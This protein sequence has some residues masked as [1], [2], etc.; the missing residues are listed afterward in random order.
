VV[1]TVRRSGG[2]AG[3]REKIGP[4]DTA[5]VANGA[6]IEA[7]VEQVGF[8]DLPAELPPAEGALS[9]PDAYYHE[10]EVVDGERQHAV[11]IPANAGQDAAGLGQLIGLVM[12]GGAIWQP[13]RSVRCHDWSAW[14]DTDGLHVAG[15]C[16]PPLGWHLVLE[17]AGPSADGTL[18][19]KSRLEQGFAETG[20]V[21][22][23]DESTDEIAQVQIAGSVNATVAVGDA[24]PQPLPPESFP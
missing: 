19:L 13:D 15:D 23:L 17:P 24:P 11:G 9:I 3:R 22:W 12:A 18:A 20:P 16:E 5:N 8:F 2:F 6:E 1:I 10:V 7:Y 14:R 4:M 21:T